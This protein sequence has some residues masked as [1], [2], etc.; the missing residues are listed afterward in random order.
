MPYI[1]AWFTPFDELILPGPRN[2]AAM[3][4]QYAQW[5]LRE[6][7]EVGDWLRFVEEGGVIFDT[8]EEAE[9]DWVAREEARLAAVNAGG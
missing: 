5:A 8:K 9:A 3:D 4:D 6:D 1:Y 7:S 2:I